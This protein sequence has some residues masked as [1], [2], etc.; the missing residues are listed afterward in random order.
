MQKIYYDGIYHVAGADAVC[1]V[2][3]KAAGSSYINRFIQP[4]SIIPGA[5]NPQNFNRYSYVGNNPIGFKDPSGHKRC[6]D[7]EDHASCRAK[8]GLGQT[9]GIHFGGW[10]SSSTNAA[11]TFANPVGLNK[12]LLKN[13]LAGSGGLQPTWMMGTIN[14]D[15]ITPPSVF[16]NTKQTDVTEWLA[17]NANIFLKFPP[18]T[19]R[20]NNPVD[21]Y[22][23]HL[24]FFGNDGIY[25][26]KVPMYEKIGGAVVMCGSQNCEW[27]DYS[28]PGNIL[29]GILSSRRGINQQIAWAAGGALE[30]IDSI[31]KGTPYTGELSA[32]GDNPGDKAAVDWG[33]QFGSTHPNGF[34]V[35][36]F[37]N[38]LTPDVLSSFQ[39]PPYTP[40][41]LLP[42]AS[43]QPN[44]YPLGFFLQR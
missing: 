18:I 37:K 21:L 6:S 34:T 41:S 40:G 29:F 26:I 10:G 43:A 12:F 28:A 44:N 15:N 17:I 38:A 14:E 1:L 31:T 2:V 39:S 42:P 9:M 32:W 8:G 11:N 27:V 25:N 33:W 13:N 30:W 24:K 36:E 5:T 22:L 23:S 4:D 19:T 35:D 20:Y 3:K 16:G 7:S